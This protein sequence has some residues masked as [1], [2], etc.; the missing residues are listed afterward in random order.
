MARKIFREV[1]RE[2]VEECVAQLLEVNANERGDAASKL[3]D[4]LKELARDIDSQLAKQPTEKMKGRH[5]RAV[6]R[7]RQMD[8]D[9]SYYLNAEFLRRDMSYTAAYQKIADELYADPKSVERG[10]KRFS[11]LVND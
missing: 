11:K 1:F 7:Q 10:H 3:A 9:R 2:T 4:H 5:S 8:Q 6:E